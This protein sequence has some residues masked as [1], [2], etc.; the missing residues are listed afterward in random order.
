MT[1]EERVKQRYPN[2]TQYNVTK[3]VDEYDL[4]ERELSARV[5]NMNPR[6]CHSPV[7]LGIERIA[8]VMANHTYGDI[9][10]YAWAF[11]GLDGFDAV[12]AVAE[13]HGLT[14]NTE[15]PADADSYIS[16]IIFGGHIWELFKMR[17]VKRYSDLTN[18][19]LE[20]YRASLQITKQ[21]RE[22][23]KV[24]GIQVRCVRFELH[25]SEVKDDYVQQYEEH[26]FI[27][28]PKYVRSTA[29]AVE[30]I[31]QFHYPNAH[32][33]FDRDLGIVLR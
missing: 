22:A 5:K 13:G 29:E 10:E 17:G 1:I 11:K 31:V 30:E 25:F 18:R 2:M 9:C 16:P 8:P 14:A 27:A 6:M 3:R 28:F 26:G 4:W 24:R 23:L 15:A 33:Q 32:L 7:Y 19:V 12:V 21:Q 20:M